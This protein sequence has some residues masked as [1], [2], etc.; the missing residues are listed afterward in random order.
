M[1]DNDRI[2][3]RVSHITTIEFYRGHTPRKYN[4]RE[5]DLPRLRYIFN[6]RLW[7]AYTDIG[8]DGVVEM[9]FHVSDRELP[10]PKRTDAEVDYNETM[11]DFMMSTRS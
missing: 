8:R 2:T 6:S 5:A 1:N 3:I 9:E 10:E 11:D 4:I 7:P